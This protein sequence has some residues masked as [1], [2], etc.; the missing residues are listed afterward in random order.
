M[1]AKYRARMASLDTEIRAL[2][3]HSGTMSDMSS[4]LGLATTCNTVVST[5]SA[6]A[7]GPRDS[8]KEMSRRAGGGPQ[9]A[10]LN[11]GISPAH[12][13]NA[14]PVE[15]TTSHVNSSIWM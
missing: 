12:G 1:V 8:G 14:T 4:T 3:S 11:E 15:T 2:T 13:S 10:T 6:S 5:S 9:F 7:D